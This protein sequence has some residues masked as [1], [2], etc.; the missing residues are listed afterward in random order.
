GQLL[1]CQLIGQLLLSSDWSADRAAGSA[2]TSY[3]HQAL[4]EF[5]VVRPIRT[6]SEGRFLSASVS[7]HQLHRSKRHSPS[8]DDEAE[9]FYNVTVFGQELHLRLRPNSRLIAPTA[10]VQ[11]EES[12]HLRSEPIR[13]DT[14]FYTGTVSDM[15]NTSVAISNCDGLVGDTLPVERRQACRSQNQALSCSVPPVELHFQQRGGPE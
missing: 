13:E 9:V 1:L 7:A 6:D 2:L 14:C 15:D 5:S 12:E 11:W 8:N 10:S 3:L 4:S